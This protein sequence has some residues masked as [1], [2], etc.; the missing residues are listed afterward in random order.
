MSCTS[1]AHFCENV[2]IQWDSDSTHLYAIGSRSHVTFVDCRES[3]HWSVSSLDPNCGVRSLAFNQQLLSVGTGAGHLYFYDLRARGWLHT[4]ND[5]LC[6]LTASSGWLVS[7]TSKGV[8]ITKSNIVSIHCLSQRHDQIYQDFFR[9][10]PPPPNA[11]YT[12]KYS[13]HR[14]KLFL[15]GGPLPTEL[16]GH[17]AAIWI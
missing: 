8:V 9:R 5:K 16:N 11:I 3:A 17:Y 14:S 10:L 12:H 15:G 2:C 1:L 6:S 13:P 7:A 4:S